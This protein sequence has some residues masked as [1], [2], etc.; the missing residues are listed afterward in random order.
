MVLIVGF[1]FI[2]VC[3]LLIINIRQYSN[4]K[5]SREFIADES[6][7]LLLAKKQTELLF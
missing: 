2:S 1:V 4:I 5:K 3:T 6:R 7:N